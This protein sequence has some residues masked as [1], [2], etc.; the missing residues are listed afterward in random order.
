MPEKLKPAKHRWQLVC[1]APPREVFA[2][3]EQ[4]CG[5]PPY[6]YEVID[7]GSARVV[8]FERK[9][10]FGQWARLA[11]RDREGRQATAADGTQLWKRPPAWVRVT[12]APHDDGYLVTVE[13]SAGRFTSARAL[14]LL[15]LLDR[16]NADRRTVYRDRRVPPGPV[17][18][19][20]SWA[21]MLYQVYTEPRYDAPR[22]PGVHTAS[23]LVAAGAEGQFIR[24]RL[25]DGTD[26][27]IE[28]DQ[29]VAAPTEAT[30]EAQTRTA[31]GQES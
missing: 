2:V 13:A 22:G 18:L 19:V 1:F 8:E 24:V 20:A 30:R 11:K 27:Y 25:E 9:G 4:M 29:L 23:H 31:L 17:T 28:A 10:V 7:R 12:M 3:F 6:R 21:G 5:T 16:G 26:G 15:D 14:Q